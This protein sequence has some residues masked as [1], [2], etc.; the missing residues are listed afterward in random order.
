MR[1]PVI[2]LHAAVVV[3]ARRHR[4]PANAQRRIRASQPQPCAPLP[5]SAQRESATSVPPTSRARLM[6]RHRSTARGKPARLSRTRMACSC[7]SSVVMSFGRVRRRPRSS[8]TRAG[9]NLRGD[10]AG[11]STPA[12]RLW[13][14]HFGERLFKRVLR[15]RF[16]AI[17]GM[18]YYL[19]QRRDAGLDRDCPLLERVSK[20]IV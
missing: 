1:I 5:H 12:G 3:G 2:A 9:K 8:R 10:R 17:S 11:E 20:T 15:G 19:L 16:L 6:I 4:D 13:R 7:G 18:T 14:S